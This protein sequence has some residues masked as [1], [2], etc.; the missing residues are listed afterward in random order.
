MTK[1]TGWLPWLLPRLSS[2]P[3]TT[4]ELSSIVPSPSGTAASASSRYLTSSAYQVLICVIQG[5][6]F[7]SVS[8]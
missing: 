2:L 3:Q 8:P 1:G 6:M 4:I 5:I 7:G